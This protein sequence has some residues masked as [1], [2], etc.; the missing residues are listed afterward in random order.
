MRPYVGD[1][2]IPLVTA[3][4]KEA[5]REF[6]EESRSWVESVS[7]VVDDGALTSIDDL[8]AGVVVVALSEARD[9]SNGKALRKVESEEW[10]DNNKINN[11]I[12]VNLSGELV[13]KN[14]QGNR[15]LAV[16]F[17]VKPGLSG[18]TVPDYLLDRWG[19]FIAAGAVARLQAQPGVK[20][21]NPNEVAFHLGRFRAGIATARTSIAGGY[22]DASVAASSPAFI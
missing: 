17:F 19:E 8:P 16:K 7:A 12:A 1:C 13:V 9:T 22:A 6:F 15:N 4:T 3:R 5:A 14:I 11:T 10:I 18:S 21:S 2:P 20:W